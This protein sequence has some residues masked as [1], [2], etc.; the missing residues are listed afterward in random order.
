M[1]DRTSIPAPDPRPR[2]CAAP[3]MLCELK[4]GQPDKLGHSVQQILWFAKNYAIYRTE[5]GVHVQFSDNDEEASEQR[6]GFTKICPELCELRYLTAQIPATKPLIFRG[7]KGYDG[8]SL[9]DHNVAQA[10][11]LVMEG[12]AKTGREIAQKALEMAIERVTNDNTLRYVCF[13]LGG[14]LLIL[15]FG[16]LLLRYSPDKSLPDDLRLFVVAGMAGATDAILSI[17]TRL[18]SFRLKP[19]NHSNM[20]YLMSI[21][22][23]GVI[24]SVAGII[25][26]LFA[27]IVLN[28]AALELIP[29]WQSGWRAPA[30][31]GLIAGFAE[32]LIPNIMRWSGVQVER[33]FGTPSQAVRAEEEKRTKDRES[34]TR[35]FAEI[36]LKQRP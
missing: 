16:A 26:W 27:P 32:R 19:C 4:E 23:V 9:Y 20:N 12:D 24:G 7:R 10:I 18:Q 36:G 5:Q 33:S 34:L 3:F 21:L 2:S 17:A 8:S 29:G 1:D 25:L 6:C 15:A 22:R 13:S 28:D 30:A 35:D 11:M 31:L 14:W